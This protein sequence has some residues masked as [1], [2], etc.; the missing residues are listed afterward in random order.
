MRLA[1]GYA[2][3]ITVIAGQD[4]V[5]LRQA[6]AQTPESLYIEVLSGLRKFVA[7]QANDACRS[8]NRDEV[9]RAPR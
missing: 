4:P 6:P 1:S 8:R 9:L 7:E 3:C 5:T 2:T